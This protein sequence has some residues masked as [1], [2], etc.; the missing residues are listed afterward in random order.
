MGKHILLEKPIAVSSEDTDKMIEACSASNVLLFDGTMWMW[1]PRTSAMKEILKRK[2]LGDVKDVAATFAFAAPPG[3]AS[4]I[5]LKKE[6]DPLGCLGDLGWY[7][8][9]AILWAYDYEVPVSVTAYPGCVTNSE[10]VPIVVGGTLLFKEG[11]RG[12]FRCS[13]DTA[14]TQRLEIC[15]SSGTILVDD[16]VIPRSET[17]AEFVVTR[18]HRLGDLDTWD[19]TI[20]D[21][22]TV[23]A[24]KPQEVS[25]WEGFA[26]CIK[27][28]ESG[29]HWT[30]VAALTQ[31]VVCLVADSMK[32]GGSCETFQSKI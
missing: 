4:N 24:E 28:A 8:I 13:F 26:R 32:N 10:G 14:L 23:H 27:N 21:T 5:R 7:C 31:K 12:N 1:H 19:A 15:G 2:Q 17:K 20:K 3:F 30:D 22:H 18:E 6:C 29:Q 16:F 25:M 9:R 11:R